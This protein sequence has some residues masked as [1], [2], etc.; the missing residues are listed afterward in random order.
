MQWKSIQIFEYGE[1]NGADVD[2]NTYELNFPYVEN[3]DSYTMNLD[4]INNGNETLTTSDYLTHNDFEILTPIQN[5]E[6]GAYQTIDIQYIAN[7]NNAS[8]SYGILSNDNDEFEVK[9]QTNGNINGANIGQEAPDFE[10]N[11][12]ANGNGTFKLSDYQGQI[13]VLAF[14]APG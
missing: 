5:I 14:F 7:A 10:L 2:L 13:V 12:I 1:V 11:I 6:P 4:V 8:G 9:C 3:G